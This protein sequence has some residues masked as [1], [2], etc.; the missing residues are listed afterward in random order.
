[1]SEEVITPKPTKQS[2]LVRYAI[3]FGIV[4][5]INLFITYAVQVV[6]PE[7]LYEQ[8]CSPEK[9]NMIYETK[10]SCVENGGQW[11]VTPSGEIKGYCDNS[12][13]CSKGYESAN[14]IFSRNVFIVFVVAG[15]LLLIGS[16][17]VPGSTLIA[18]AVSLAGVLALIIG[19][20]AH[21]SNMN[22]V[23]RLVVL[24]VALVAILTLAWK[25]F[26]DA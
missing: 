24:G 18:S 12:F 8:F 22:D 2:V 17:F 5:L 10:E 11:N 6:Y 3:L 26:K 13:E 9:V 1:M 14:K 19:S 16:L 4:I 20:I 21:W 23:L 15:L 25:K 7:P